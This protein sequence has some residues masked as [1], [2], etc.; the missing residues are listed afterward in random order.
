MAIPYI[1]L[2]LV[3]YILAFLDPLESADLRTNVAIS[4]VSRAW[5]TT[6]LPNLFEALVVRFPKYRSGRRT[7]GEWRETQILADDFAVGLPKEKPPKTE[8]D[9]YDLWDEDEDDLFTRGDTRLINVI[10]LSFLRLAALL[11]KTRDLRPL[12]HTFA[13]YGKNTGRIGG[14]ITQRCLELCG[15]SIERVRLVNRYREERKLVPHTF[16]SAWCLKSFAPNVRSLTCHHV[17]HGN[18]RDFISTF[19]K[20]EKL[21]HLSFSFGAG[22]PFGTL[23][24]YASSLHIGSHMPIPQLDSFIR[25]SAA[26]LLT[27]SFHLERSTSAH[28]SSLTSLQT[29]SLGFTLYGDAAKT[30]STVPSSLRRVELRLLRK[31]QVNSTRW[32]QHTFKHTLGSLPE[33]ITALRIPYNLVVADEPAEDERNLLLKTLAKPDWL[34]QLAFLGVLG[35]IWEK[36]AEKL[37]STEVGREKLREACEKW[38]VDLTSTLRRWQDIGADEG[39]LPATGMDELSLDE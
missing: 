19:E 30:L 11:K 9:D 39:E 1:P 37:A 35:V 5:R 10:D 16:Q 36:D 7:L 6:A 28:L 3:A 15:D 4:K 24:P 8:E 29:L 18:L 33:S 25:P 20:L 14:D 31:Y 2:E 22:L 32:P 34:P 38:A 12:V 26:S 27:L 13:Y 17:H 23:A 21:E